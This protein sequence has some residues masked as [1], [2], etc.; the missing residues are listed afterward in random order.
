[1]AITGIAN[2]LII[3]RRVIW[4]PRFNIELPGLPGLLAAPRHVDTGTILF[5]YALMEPVSI[6][7]LPALSRA[8]S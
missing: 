5:I 6:C 3:L 1:M 2:M 7:G 8:K 4:C